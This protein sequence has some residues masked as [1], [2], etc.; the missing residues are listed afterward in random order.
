MPFTN[1]KMVNLFIFAIFLCFGEM[2]AHNASFQCDQICVVENCADQDCS[3]FNCTKTATKIAYCLKFIIIGGK[4]EI[5]KSFSSNS[6]NQVNFSSL[7]QCFFISINLFLFFLIKQ[8]LE[9][10]LP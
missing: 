3:L 2:S 5:C 9:T 7:F 6:S 1:E 8:S 10:S 4:K